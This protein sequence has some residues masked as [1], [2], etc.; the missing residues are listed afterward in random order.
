MDI[1]EY[2]FGRWGDERSQKNNEVNEKCF[3]F[4]KLFPLNF[5]TV[6]HSDLIIWLDN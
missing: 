1:T 6:D 5:L 2:N 3:F 4:F